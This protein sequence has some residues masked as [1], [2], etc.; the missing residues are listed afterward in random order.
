ML[1]LNDDLIIY[2]H[3]QACLEIQVG[4]KRIFIDPFHIK[5]GIADIILITHFHSSHFSKE[6]IN[7][8]RKD[9]TVIITPIKSPI[10][11]QGSMILM[12][13]Y[14]SVSI[15]N[16]YIKAIPAYNTGGKPYHPRSYNWLGY[17]LVINNTS[18]YHS[19]DT[20]DIPEMKKLNGIDVAF[21]PVSG[22][23]VMNAQR[24]ALAA[25]NF[26]P[27]LAVPIHWGNNKG[28]IQDAAIFKKLYKGN[29]ALI[30]PSM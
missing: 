15:G 13:P 23:S 24:A 9:N 2:W 6:D 1:T 18:I 12:K 25:N 16:I 27:K 3:G 20:D 17:V 10:D 8:L 28:S 5:E 26:K 7:K 22:T 29:A 14:A 4:D 11:F 21:L 30:K 19:G